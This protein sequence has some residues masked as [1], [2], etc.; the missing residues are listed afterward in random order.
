MSSYTPKPSKDHKGWYEIPGFSGCCANR[1]GE[2]LTKKTGHR[3]KGGNAGRY[4]K[5]SAYKDGNDK[6]SLYHVHDLI[7]RA[8]RG[9]PKKGQVVLHGND[10][11]WDNRASNLCWG[12]Q[13]QNVKDGWDRGCRPRPSQETYPSYLDW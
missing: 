12:S 2:I 7:C 9:P 3:T 10:N 5:I 1:S 6:P 4:L 8:F 13:S 11:R